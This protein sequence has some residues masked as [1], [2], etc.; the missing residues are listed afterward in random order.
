MEILKLDH[1][2]KAAASIG[3][4]IAVAALGFGN[5]EAFLVG[6]GVALYGLGEWVN[7]PIH[8]RF[9]PGSNPGQTLKIYGYKRHN[10]FTGIL[11]AV[12]GVVVTALG[13]YTIYLSTQ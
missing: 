6:F 8:T 1:W 7:H 2:T 5:N 10:S 13:A 9:Q 4:A 11:L 3:C 12:A